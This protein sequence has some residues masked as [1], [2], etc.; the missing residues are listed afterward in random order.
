MLGYSS[1]LH[2]TEVLTSN[3]IWKTV[4]MS[5]PHIPLIKTLHSLYLHANVGIFMQIMQLQTKFCRII[6]SQFLLQISWLPLGCLPSRL[7]CVKSCQNICKLQHIDSYLAW[8][9]TRTLFPPH[10]SPH[11][12]RGQCRGFRYL[13]L[14]HPLHLAAI[15][16]H[17]SFRLVFGEFHHL[18]GVVSCG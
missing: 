7:S 2:M 5:F 8:L 1:E 14:L 9:V 17:H 6:Q 4:I 18:P 11:W 13:A 12:A 16:L 3:N 10:F 15:V